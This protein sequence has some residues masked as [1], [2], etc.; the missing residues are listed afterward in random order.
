MVI[1]GR[2]GLPLDCLPRRG[3]RPFSCPDRRPHVSPTGTNHESGASA[4][5][6]HAARQER[7]RRC[8]YLSNDRRTGYH[9]HPHPTPRPLRMTTR[10]YRRDDPRMRPR[11][12]RAAT[13]PH[14]STAA[15]ALARGAATPVQRPRIVAN[16]QR[17]GIAHA[18]KVRLVLSDEQYNDVTTRRA[19]G[20]SWA[21]LARAYGMTQTT[22]MAAYARQTAAKRQEQPQ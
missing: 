10:R 2:R 3:L 17:A 9:D 1:L 6:G 21:G 18:A 12:R 19:D 13:R 5:A 11:G 7:S 8:H 15:A 20:E 16:L 14:G 4:D 22:L